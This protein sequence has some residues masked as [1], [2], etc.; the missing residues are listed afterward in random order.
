[1]KLSAYIA[2]VFMAA[3]FEC[4]AQDSNYAFESKTLLIE[5][6]S[7]N[8]F[9]HVSWLETENFGKVACN[10]MVVKDKGEALIFDTPVD[11]T[12]SRELISWIKDSLN[13]KP[14]GIVVTHF[15]NDCLGGLAEFHKARI[16]SYAH[17]TTIELAK[18][19]A[20]SSL[21]QNGFDHFLETRVGDGVVLN[22]F[23]GEG[24]TKDN[25]VCYFPG[26]KVLFGGCL[27]KGMGA[28]KGHLDDANLEEWPGTVEK[29]LRKYGDAAVV[30]PGH[31]D[32]GGPELLEYTIRLFKGP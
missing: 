17:N 12:A 13:C 5:R 29:V 1:M 27:V 15:H 22:E 3:L 32:P 7:E 10:G 24:H 16:P 20:V 8:T 26:D 14:K 9:R 4:H 31:G 19:V 2:L 21:P 11:E 23:F 18:S 25:I 6:L 30:I 28:G